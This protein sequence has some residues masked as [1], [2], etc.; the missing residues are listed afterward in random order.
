MAK[1]PPNEAYRNANLDAL[2]ARVDEWAESE[3]ARLDN[4]VMFL[5]AILEG[6]KASNT[7]TKNLATSSKLLQVEIA[8]FLDSGG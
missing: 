4:E 5:K 3:K 8:D 1:I 6:R 7:G 2:K